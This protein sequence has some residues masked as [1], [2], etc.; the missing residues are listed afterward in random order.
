MGFMYYVL[1]NIRERNL[2]YLFCVVYVYRVTYT[3]T[4]SCQHKHAY[5]G[6]YKLMPAPLIRNFEYFGPDW[7]SLAYIWLM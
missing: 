6:F 2:V 1:I 5:G 3:H 4:F 7:S